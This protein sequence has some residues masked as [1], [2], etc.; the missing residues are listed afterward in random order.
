MR[1]QDLGI[2]IGAYGLDPDRLIEAMKRYGRF[3]VA[4]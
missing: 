1:V 4:G 2:T 3:R